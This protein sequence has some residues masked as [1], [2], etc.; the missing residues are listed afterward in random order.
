MNSLLL[1]RLVEESHE[2]LKASTLG[3]EYLR[4]ARHFSVDTITRERMGF[5]DREVASSFLSEHGTDD[6]KWTHGADYYAEMLCGRVLLPIRDDTG[7][8]VAV[9]TRIPQ[10]D[11]K[12]WWNSPFSKE[13]VLYGLNY[14]K[15][16]VFARDKIY[17]VE[18]YA[19]A[20]SLWRA[21]LRNVVAMMGTTITR[22][23]HGL[24]LRYCS[25]ICACY[26]TDPMVGGRLGGGQAGLERMVAECQ[27]LKFYDTISAIVM[28]MEKKD[29]GSDLGADPDDF[30][31]KNGLKDYLDLER[32]VL[33][34]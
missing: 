18:G 8:I 30:V 31:R 12:G 3:F 19:D 27:N 14:A 9:S 26:D 34:Y 13:N 4:D 23:Q 33:L 5:C 22:I 32:R 1:N 11:T 7:R 20:I 10:K 16:A 21:G 28:P 15:N 25:N 17:V 2:K 29:D 6:S 24:I